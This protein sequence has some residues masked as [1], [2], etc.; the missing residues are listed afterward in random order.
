MKRCRA[1]HPTVPRSPFW[2]SAPL[3][4]R[5]RCELP[6]GHTE[7]HQLLGGRTWARGKAARALYVQNQQATNK[8]HRAKHKRCLRRFIKKLDFQDRIRSEA[9]VAR[10]QRCAG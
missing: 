10:F 5:E 4:R 2:S 7:R 3:P 1:R 8:R 6:A 9:T